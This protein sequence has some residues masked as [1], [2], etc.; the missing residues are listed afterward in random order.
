MTKI[1][2]DAELRGIIP[3]LSEQEKADL[4]ASIVAEGCR[5]ALVVWPRGKTAVLLD[6]HH[7]MEI[8]ERVGVKYRTVEI[9]LKDKRAA[10][11]W[12]RTNALARRNLSLYW[13]GVLALK[14]L[15]DEKAAAKERQ[16]KS[17]G[18]GKKVGKDF[19]TSSDDGGKAYDKAAK[20]ADMSGVT[21]RKVEYVEHHGDE[22]TKQDARDDKIKVEKA[23]RE[24]RKRVM[25]ADFA[26]ADAEAIKG[27]PPKGKMYEVRKLDINRALKWPADGSVDWIVT[28]PPYEKAGLPLWS[29]LSKFALRVL[30]PGGSLVA[31][32]G[33]IFLPEIVCRLGDPPDS[34]APSEHLDYYA[35]LAYML[36]RS[37]MR[38]AKCKM[39][40]GW[41]P[42][43]WYS[44]G[45]PKHRAVSTDVVV[46][47]APEKQAGKHHDKAWGQSLA[48]MINIIERVTQ[49]GQIICDPFV[50]AG[51]TA[52]A[53]VSTGRQFRGL[54]IEQSEVNKCARRLA[55]WVKRRDD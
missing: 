35:T 54:D 13:K 39:G 21:L 42:L 7:R 24:T 1:V 50:G 30:K 17:P 9:K 6:G 51:T 20:D 55:E 49:A 52:I 37:G 34:N 3:E 25:K 10:R 8:C 44:K 33:Y 38:I 4:E 19:P 12:M 40:Q 41:K 22:K 2:V 36:P 27:N 47:P 16:R 11:V 15:E 31:M 18:R 32:S 23:Y 53:A 43:F 46:S 14:I 29:A 5:D 28:D 26:K 45:K 48:G